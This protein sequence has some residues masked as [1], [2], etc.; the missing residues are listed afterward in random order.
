MPQQRPPLS[1]LDLVPLSEGMSPADAIAVSMRAAQI[2]DEC[3][4]RRYWFAEHH[5]T[6]S[7]ASS[8]TALLIA[9]AAERTENIRVG[10]GGIMLPNH[11]PLS[12]IEQ[13]GTLVNMY[14]PRVDLGLGRA[15]GTDQVTAQLLARSSAEPEAF[16]QSVAQM[17][18]W[19]SAEHAGEF[20]VNA[21]AAEAT[22]VPMWVLGSTVNGALLAAQLGLPFAFASHFAPQQML[23]ALK[24]YRDNFSSDRETAQIESPHTMVAVNVT[25]AETD[26][27]AEELFT[28]HQ[29]MF[30]GV[31]TGKRQK[32]QPAAPIDDDLPEA[33]QM[34]VEQSLSVRAIGSPETVAAKLQ[35]IAEQTGADELIVS[36]YY[37][38]PEDRYRALQLLMDAWR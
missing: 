8:A 17:R 3:G 21:T 10:S 14:G 2:A 32:L 19:S 34:H 36:G 26:E 5:N 23:Q 33:V 31:V 11:S 24:T 20:R 13:F 12:V 15:P 37:F 30:A 7:L 27:R 22:E 16:M 38:E 35:Q 6:V 9:Q 4:Y 25:V 28:T 18:A 29:R 1:I